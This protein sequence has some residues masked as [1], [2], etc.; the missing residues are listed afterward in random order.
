MLDADACY[1]ALRAHDARFDG[2]FFV[3]V[4]STG[5]YCRP[6][7]PARAVRRENARFFSSAAAAERES[8]RPCL[9]CRPELAP[10]NARIDSSVQL[11]ARA[12]QHIDSGALNEKSVDEL[13]LE[14][15]VTGRHLRRVV[16]AEFGVTPIE[17]A[18]TQRLLLAKQLLTD[19]ALPMTEIAFASGFSS[20]RR[21]NALFRQRYR[22]N[23]SRLRQTRLAKDA[24]Y[25]E[26]T[27]RPPFAWRSI[28]DFLAVRSCP[29]V[30]AVVEDRY[31][32]TVAIGKHSGWL[33][34]SPSPRRHS[35]RVE[36]SSSLAPVLLAV[37]TRVKRLFDLNAHP[38][39]IEEHLGACARLAPL[40]AANS[41][42]RVPG[43]FDG[44]EMTVRAI[45]GQQV[46]VKAATTMAGRLASNFGQSI[47]TPFPALTH[48][49]PTAACMAQ[50]DVEDLTR[51]GIIGNR[52]RSILAVA[53][54][55]LRLEPGADVKATLGQLRELPGI[56][57]W[58][59]Q[60]I[61]MRALHWPDAF[62]HTDLG[63]YKAL[64]VR[65]PKE[66]LEIS[67]KWLPW[68][69]YATMYLWKSLT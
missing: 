34:V 37:L 12:L 53:D 64:A 18:Q 59:A 15:G 19:T 41:G 44:F 61:A 13:G 24:L 62:P 26:I 54:A 16:E 4:T 7:C 63:V 32:R 14:L 50:L 46:S 45:L 25:C 43:A 47:E 35:L 36:L 48:I 29:G 38:W 68:R 21:F 2:V 40:I 27:Y 67:R 5:I 3:G 57:E 17:L 55:D 22:L 11:A 8:F 56:G 49:S 58:T 31:I 28:L 23:P 9:R 6:V 51:L 65:S 30:E 39:R 66:V 10:G 52:A 42:L 1:L 33:A 60:Y 69:A 20:I